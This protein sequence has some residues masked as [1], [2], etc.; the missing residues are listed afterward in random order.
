[1]MEFSGVNE[2]YGSSHILVDSTETIARG[3]RGRIRLHMEQDEF[4]GDAGA[5]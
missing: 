2:Y 3:E 1:M 5:P 4:F